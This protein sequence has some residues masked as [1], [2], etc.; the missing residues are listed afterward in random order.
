MSSAASTEK[1][2]MRE[3]VSAARASASRRGP[4]PSSLPNVLNKASAAVLTPATSCAQGAW[5]SFT[6]SAT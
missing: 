5:A 3:L 6:N 1:I 4:A 2:Q